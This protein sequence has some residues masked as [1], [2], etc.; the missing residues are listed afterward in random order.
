MTLEQWQEEVQDYIEFL[1]MDYVFKKKDFNSVK[2][3]KEFL[4]HEIELCKLLDINLDNYN[5]FIE[6]ITI[7]YEDRINY[8]ESCLIVNAL[9]SYIGNYMKY[10]KEVCNYKEEEIK[11]DNNI[12]F[13][14]KTLKKYEKLEKDIMNLRIKEDK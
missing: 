3:C 8:N 9:N 5:S 14:Q 12:K 4:K 13:F 2:K 6:P 7:H 10:L 11:E 1:D